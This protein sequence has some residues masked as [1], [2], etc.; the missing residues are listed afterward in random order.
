MRKKRGKKRKNM[1][2][3]KEDEEKGRNQEVFGNPG[4]F[5]VS[6]ERGIKIGKRGELEKRGKV[7]KECISTGL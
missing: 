4:Y 3:G 7:I 1:V 2:K 5:G 6:E